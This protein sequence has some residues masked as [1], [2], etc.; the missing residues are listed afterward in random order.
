MQQS[1]EF[2]LDSAGSGGETGLVLGSG[3]LLDIPLAELACRFESLILVDMVHLPE[4]R[5][6]VRA[7]PGV[8]LLEADVTGVV[9]PLSALGN[10]PG[11]ANQAELEACFACWPGLTGLDEVDWVASV[12][13]FS[14]LPLLPLARA[15]MLLPDVSEAVLL[16]WQET[17]LARHLEWVRG[18]APRG[19]VV[20]DACQEVWGPG[21]ELLEVMDYRPYL[22]GL[23]AAREEWIWLLAPALE[24][25]GEGRVQ[26]RVQGWQW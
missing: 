9:R 21:G 8:R 23:G 13:L 15:E 3:L 7:Y 10:R 22:Q 20:T 24:T 12:N 4:V 14:Q 18:V 2:L 26:H 1:R 5:R 17:L 19:C 6:Q 16:R 11:A 25:G